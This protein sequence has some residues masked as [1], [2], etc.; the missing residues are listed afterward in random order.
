MPTKGQ[1]AATQYAMVGL[2]N[3][4]LDAANP[5]NRIAHERTSPLRLCRVARYHKGGLSDY[6]MAERLKA[7]LSE[8]KQWY[9]FTELG[10][11]ISQMYLQIERERF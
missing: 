2:I 3:T 5:R 7:D 1:I 11:V 10:G 6:E 9:D 4:F 8:F